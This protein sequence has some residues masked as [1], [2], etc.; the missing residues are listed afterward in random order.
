MTEL[1]QTYYRAEIKI[2]NNN[3]LSLIEQNGYTNIANFC[4]VNNL[5]CSLLGS[6]ANLK[7]SPFLNDQTGYRKT[8]LDISFALGALPED[9]WPSDMLLVLENNSGF[10]KINKGQAETLI[11]QSSADSLVLK[12]ERTKLIESAM[13]A[14][15]ERTKD[16]V[17]RRSKGQTFKLISDVYGISVSRAREIEAKGIRILKAKNQNS[18]TKELTQAYEIYNK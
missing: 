9:I 6:Y 4:K 5:S 16:I 12:D 14:L 17:V 15:N 13:S 11:A 1:K 2:K 3:L 10:A 7:V 18:K 8:A